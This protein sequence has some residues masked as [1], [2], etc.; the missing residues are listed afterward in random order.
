LTER[1]KSLF[2]PLVVKQ[3]WQRDTQRLGDPAQVQDRDV[4][5]AALDGA[6]EGTVQPARIG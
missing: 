1:K 4:P 2:F 6:D 3:I 5:F